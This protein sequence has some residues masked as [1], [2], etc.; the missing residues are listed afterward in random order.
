MHNLYN[1]AYQ[2]KMA[3]PLT[4]NETIIK[5]QLEIGMKKIK[6]RNQW[7]AYNIKTCAMTQTD[8]IQ[9]FL[10]FLMHHSHH[11]QHK[12]NNNHHSTSF[13]SDWYLYAKFMQILNTRPTLVHT[14]T[15]VQ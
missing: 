4:N 6:N 5:I 2:I 8:Y 13:G 12:N 10:Y 3:K 15:N 14:L 7:A 11:H 1:F 9:I